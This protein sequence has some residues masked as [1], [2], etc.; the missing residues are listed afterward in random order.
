MRRTR[1]LITLGP[2]SDDPVTI[3]ALLDAGAD[4]VRL[5]FSHG[6]VDQHR[7]TCARVRAAAAEAGRTVGVLQDLGGPKIRIGPLEAPIALR[8]GDHLT[9]EKGTFT[10]A[11]GRVACNFD[12]LFT[13]AERGH[14]L[15]LDDG[16]IELKVVDVGA[17]GL[18]TTV[19][20]GGTLES[21]KGINIPDAALQVPAMT[22][23]DVDDLRAGVAMGVDMIALSFVQSADDILAARAVA[24]D[25]GAADLP[26]VAK[27]ERP[28]AVDQ[29]DDILRVADGLMVARGDLGIEMPIETLP[30]VQGRLIRAARRAAVPVIVATQVLESM[31]HD[32]RPTRAEV[33]DAAHAV[34]QS[35]DAIML[36]GETAAGRYPIRAVSTLDAVI[37]E[38][39]QATHSAAPFDGQGGAALGRAH[40]VALAEAAVTLAARAGAAAIVAVT[41]GGKTARMLAALRPP[42][43]LL[44]A[45]ASAHT[46]A[47][48][49]LVW[50]ITPL[51]AA[52]ASIPALRHAIT[53]RGLLSAGTAVVFVAIH[54]ELG[55]DG[56]NFVRVE[57]L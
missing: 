30:T 43:P 38:A 27:I 54:P 28:R 11:S 44:A 32:P 15:L 50:G 23:K 45:T 57:R 8:E 6:T 52:D 37:R 3:R 41:E 24:A 35:A 14:R 13:T 40:G 17:S 21:R 48:L 51:V 12:A 42:V 22:A 53:E 49:S 1:I 4:A 26:I 20:I 7:E 34:D 56:S 55:H 25:A 47:R 10:G 29:I 16:R 36:A 9:I 46:G 19:V 33:T 2:A 39:E 31:R 5:N 18:S